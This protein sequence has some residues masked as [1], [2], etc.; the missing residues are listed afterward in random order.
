LLRSES[1]P[2]RLLAVRVIVHGTSSLHDRLH[3]DPERYVAEVRNLALER[4]KD[5][6]WIEKVEFQTRA[7]RAIAV[8]DGPIEELR[9]V[10]RPAQRPT[11]AALATLGEELG[12]P[13]AQAPLR[14]AP[15]P[16]F[17][18]AGRPPIGCSACSTR[19]SPCCS[20]CSSIPNARAIHEAAATIPEGDRPVHGRRARPVGRPLRPAPDLRPQRGGKTSTL[21]AL[22]HLLFGFPVRTPDDFVHPYDQLRVGAGTAA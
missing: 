10:A 7:A 16:R 11:P 4:G 6:L 18:A 12:R 13:E 1:D 9:E 19:S 8:H 15:R 14:A 22:S 5:R 3:A 17:A 20:T 21:R 2:D